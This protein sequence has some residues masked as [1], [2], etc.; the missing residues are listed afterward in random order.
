M[1]ATN[2]RLKQPGCVLPQFSSGA[3]VKHEDMGRVASSSG[4]RRRLLRRLQLPPS[5]SDPPGHPWP[6]PCVCLQEA[7]PV[8]ASLLFLSGPRAHCIKGS[9]SRSASFLL[10]TSAMALSPSKV[11][12][13]G[14][15]VRTSVCLLGG[16]NSTHKRREEEGST[17]RKGRKIDPYRLQ[18]NY[19]WRITASKIT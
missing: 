1:T 2:G 14:S 9:Y 8:C 13:W 10:T 19:T 6:S 18:W 16:H 12:F 11:G 4:L 17:E 3:E 7:S 5:V 15:S